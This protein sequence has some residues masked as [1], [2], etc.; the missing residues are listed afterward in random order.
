MGPSPPPLTS[1][2]WLRW[3]VVRPILAGLEGVETILEVGTGL[4]GFGARLASRYD[5]VGLEPDERSWSVARGRIESRGGRVLR[6]GIDALPDGAAFDLVCAFEVLEHQADD[7]ATLREWRDRAA[8][9]GWLLL[10]VPAFRR[11]FGPWDELAGH[12]RRYDPPDLARAV[13]AAGFLPPRLKTYG[14]PVGNLTE[15]IRHRIAGGAGVGVTMAQRTARSGRNQPSG[16]VAR[17]VDLA[18]IPGRILQRVTPQG[19][20]M[21][22]V[23]L[24]RNR[25][26]G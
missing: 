26:D 5:Y 19:R 15:R 12:Y 23:A 22:L 4:G 21:G 16:V 8:S 9:E 14:F 7:V 24:A 2:G 1:T 25:R 10:S 11:R 18:A 20:G 17:L 3:D 6:G 13:E